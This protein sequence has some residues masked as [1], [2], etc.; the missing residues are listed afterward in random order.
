M[1]LT[2]KMFHKLYFRKPDIFQSTD[3]HSANNSAEIPVK[4]PQS[5]VCFC[6]KSLGLYCYRSSDNSSKGFFTWWDWS[7]LSDRAKSCCYPAAEERNIFLMPKLGSCVHL[8]SRKLRRLK[9][10]VWLRRGLD[11][12]ECFCPERWLKMSKV[13]PDAE[14]KAIC[15]LVAQK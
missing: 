8:I 13:T 12:E 1:K 11:W 7:H 4:L 14:F 5:S 3:S 2:S 9:Q 15:R 6:L 10:L